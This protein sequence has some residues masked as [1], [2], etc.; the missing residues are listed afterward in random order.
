MQM[1]WRNILALLV[2]IVAG[3]C[4][5]MGVL[6]IGS[7]LIPAP[8]G[9]DIGN[10]ES[11]KTQ[12]HLYQ[13]NQFLFP[14]LAHALGTFTGVWV[15]ML[16]AKTR[17]PIRYVI[18]FGSFYFIGGLSM[19]LILPSPLWFNILDLTLA[20]FPMAYLGNKLSIK[21]EVPAV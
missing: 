6:E 2:G 7:K 17:Y 9:V 3:S 20:Y 8:E 12:I 4:F 15:F 16:L 10:F 11:I 13:P 21:K 5:N 18:V 14:F 19:V 1:N